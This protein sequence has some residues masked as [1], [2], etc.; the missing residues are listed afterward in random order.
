M[1]GKLEEN[2]TD[3]SLSQEDCKPSNSTWILIGT[4][5]KNRLCAKWLKG[6]HEEGG[7]R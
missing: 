3:H 6:E 5:S 4:E 1:K 7:R 2:R